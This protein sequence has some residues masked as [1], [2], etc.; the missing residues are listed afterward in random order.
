MTKE[1]HVHEPLFQV[2]KRG[3]LSLKKAVLIRTCAISGSILFI[4]LFC[5]IILK[6]N[7]IEILIK[8]FEGSFGNMNRFWD[9]LKKTALLLLVGIAL[10]PAFKMKFWNLGGNGQ[11]LVGGLAAVACM[12]YLGGKMDDA[13]VNIIMVISSVVAGAI[14]AV[15]PSIFKAIFKTNESL[16]TLMMNYIAAGLVAFFVNIWDLSGRGI[17]EPLPHGHLPELG[18]AEL[19]IIIVA[20]ILT[21]FMYFYMKHSKHGYEISLIGEGEKT[22]KYAGMSVKK[23]VLRTLAISGAICGIVGLLIAGAENHTIAK[24]DHGN[25]GFTAII[26]AWMGKFNPLM[27]IGTSFLVNF[28]SK[29]VGHFQSSMNITDPAIPEM[30]VALVYLI[31]IACEFF[32]VYKVKFRKRN[33][34]DN[35][36]DFLTAEAQTDVQKQG[37]SKEKTEGDK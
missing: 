23:V 35:K 3:D 11:I 22:A 34:V 25:F 27:M 29:G 24:A 17:L 33:K 20:T 4:C 5:G 32:I 30:M 31:I 14:W 9:V 21:T 6:A 26:V 1:K 13:I 12:Y 16:F 36:K 8:L 37:Q 15:I 10:V 28:L 18:I 2:S 7:P 19:L